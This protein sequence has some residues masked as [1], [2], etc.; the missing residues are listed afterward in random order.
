[1]WV[2]KLLHEL[3]SRI[4][5]DGRVA[6]CIYLI[7]HLPD[8][9]RFAGPRVADDQKVLVFG[10]AWNSQRQLRVIGGDANSGAF[11]SLVERF[12]IDQDR[13]FQAATVAELFDTPDVL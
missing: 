13:A 7:K 2:V 11:D 3:A 8:D 4:V 12:G 1:M 5:Y 9:A 10:I 6:A